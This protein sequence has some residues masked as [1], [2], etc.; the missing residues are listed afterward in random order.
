MSFFSQPKPR[1]FHHQPIYYDE[2]TDRVK[3]IERRAR[4]ELGLDST[5]ESRR[6]S[7][8]GVFTNDVREKRQRRGMIKRNALINNTGAVIVIILVLLLFWIYLSK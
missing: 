7:L 4:K 5:P 2:H 6:E 8:R 3:N 1:R